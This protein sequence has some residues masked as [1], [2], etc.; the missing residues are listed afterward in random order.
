MQQAK[1]EIEDDILAM[2]RG[3]E[4]A[5]RKEWVPANGS[6]EANWPT[7]LKPEGFHGLAG[8]WVQ[9]VEPHTEADPAALLVQFLVAF[10]SLIGRKP[11]HRAESDRHFTNLFAVIVG[12]TSKGRKGTSWGQ[13]KAI[14][15]H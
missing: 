11:H 9:M 6:L 15:R 3:H 5:T 14:M 8:E 1:I 2:L 4:P 7:A 13:V 10:G 12:L